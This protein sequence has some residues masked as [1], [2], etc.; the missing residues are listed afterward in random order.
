MIV[1]INGPYPCG[2]FSDVR[3][4]RLGLKQYLENNE[5][6][7][8]DRGYCDDRCINPNNELSQFKRINAIIR[9]RHETVNARLK[10][11]SILKME[12]RHALSHHGDVFY[13]VANLVQLMIETTDPLFSL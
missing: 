6:I 10:N 11:F 1:W 9:A 4:F 8:G 7:I 13:A 5:K 12:F 2:S 3:I